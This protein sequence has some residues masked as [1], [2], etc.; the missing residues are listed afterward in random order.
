M[1]ESWVQPWAGIVGAALGGTNNIRDC[2]MAASVTSGGN[3]GGVLGHG[4]TS[5]T[6]ISNCFLTGSLKGNSIGVF[7]GGG[8]DGGVHAIENCWTEGSYDNQVDVYLLYSEGGTTSVTNC[9]KNRNDISQGSTSGAWYDSQKAFFLGSQWTTDNNGELVLK[10]SAEFDYT[11]INDP[12]FTG[13]TFDNSTAAQARQTVSFTGGSFRGSYDPVSL[14]PNDKSNLFL[15]TGNTL[16]WPNAANNTDG[17]Y[18]L[19]ACRAFFH[20]DDGNTVKAF[21][22]NFGDEDETTGIA[23]LLSPQGG[24]IHSPLVE[25]EG[26][27]WYTIDGRKLQTPSLS[28]SIGE[29]RGGLPHGIYINNGRKV[30]IK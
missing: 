21:V 26:A 28:P 6:T 1:R 25:T 27:S 16:Y 19:N 11:A 9:I 17:N 23:A 2:W 18:H 5:A 30:V 10:P 3:M 13:V 15:G 24:T 29:D 12:V 22:L 14:T 4:T 8:Y 7:Y 20:I